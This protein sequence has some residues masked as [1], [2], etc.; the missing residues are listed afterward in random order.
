MYSLA[1]IKGN[2]KREAPKKCLFSGLSG[3]PYWI[4]TSGLTLRRTIEHLSSVFTYVQ[5]SRYPSGFFH[6]P[7]RSVFVQVH[8]CR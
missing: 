8:W 2:E 6:I 7:S 1:R 3:A 5:E 4:R